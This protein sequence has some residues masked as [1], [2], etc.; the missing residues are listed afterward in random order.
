MHHH[1]G[2]EVAYHA[3][4]EEESGHDAAEDDHQRGEVVVNSFKQAVKGEGKQ[5]EDDRADQVGS[6]AQ[7]EEP[8]V[9]GDVGGGCGCISRHEELAGNVNEAKRAKDD[10]EQI[11][12][13]GDSSGVSCWAH[14]VS[15]DGRNLV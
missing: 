4:E 7:A 10:E 15:L 5:D 3:G 1:Q 12:E 2:A 8:L 6:D 13:S 11:P 14:V 9:G